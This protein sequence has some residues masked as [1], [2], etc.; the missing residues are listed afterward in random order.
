MTSSPSGLNRKRSRIA[1]VR[2]LG[3]SPTYSDTSS[4]RSSVTSEARSAA[5]VRVLA[6]LMKPSIASVGKKIAA[7]RSAASRRAIYFV[8]PNR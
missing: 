2:P 7:N 3:P 6:K 8:A 5:S 4:S 1:A